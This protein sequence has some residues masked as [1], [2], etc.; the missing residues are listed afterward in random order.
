MTTIRP[1]RGGSDVTVDIRIAP[2]GSRVPRGGGLRPRRLR[3]CPPA[4]RP[5]TATRDARD[6]RTRLP[7]VAHTLPVRRR[8]T[9]YHRAANAVLR[10]A[11]NRTRQGRRGLQLR[12]AAVAGH[13]RGAGPHVRHRRLRLD[14]RLLDG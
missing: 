6:R 1:G 13:P 5:G 2:R 8:R 10:S 9:A 11:P 7:A 12:L 4:T 3:R 14:A